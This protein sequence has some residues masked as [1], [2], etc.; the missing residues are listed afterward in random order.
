MMKLTV[1]KLKIQ[2]IFIKVGD[3]KKQIFLTEDEQKIISFIDQFGQ[4]NSDD[5]TKILSVSKRTAQL[6]LLKLK[7]SG[8]IKQIGQGPSSTYIID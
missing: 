3:D 2:Q 4:T 7:K 1:L 6:R 8:L 5:I